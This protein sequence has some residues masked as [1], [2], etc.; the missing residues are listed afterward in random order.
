MWT[1]EQVN[2]I[3]DTI[4]RFLMVRGNQKGDRVSILLPNTPEFVITFYG[5]P[6]AG[7]V[8]MA[9]NP[10]YRPTGVKTQAI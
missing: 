6:K 8:V 5:I 2:A 9:I 1:Y 3:S 7:G 4:A 10:T